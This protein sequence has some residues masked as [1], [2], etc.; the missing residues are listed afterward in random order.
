[1]GP[2]CFYQLPV[3]LQAAGL[4]DMDGKK[5]DG[6]KGPGT[7]PHSHSCD[8][9]PFQKLPRPP[10]GLQLQS[11]GATPCPERGFLCGAPSHHKLLEAGGHT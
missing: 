9:P 2:Q 10:G 7:H 1:M 4:S 5:S 6:K 8:G 3:T 11:N